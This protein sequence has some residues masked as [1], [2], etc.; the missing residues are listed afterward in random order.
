MR[1]CPIVHQLG[2]QK[3]M[4]RMKLGTSTLVNRAM[5]KATNAAVRHNPRMEAVCTA[6]LCRHADKHTLVVVIVAAMV[7]K[8][9][10][11]RHSVFGSE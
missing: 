9:I 1:P 6:V 4:S 8:I 2:D 11:I 5:C 3:C 10:S 7:N